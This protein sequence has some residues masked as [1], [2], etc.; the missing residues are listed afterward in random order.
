MLLSRLSYIRSRL[1]GAVSRLDGAVSMPGCTR[2]RLDGA[3]LY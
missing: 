2:S 1:G 3:R